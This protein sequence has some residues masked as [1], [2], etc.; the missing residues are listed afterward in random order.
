V[1][2]LGEVSGFIAG[3]VLVRGEDDWPLPGTAWA[4]LYLDAGRT[5]SA[6]SLNDGALAIRPS[7]SS[8]SDMALLAST[9]SASAS[10]RTALSAAGHG[11]EGFG[12]PQAVAP[13]SNLRAAEATA[14]TYT[15]APLAQNLELSGPIVLRV[16]ASATATDFDWAVNLTDVW[17]DG[18]SEWI[19]DG[20]LRASLRRVDQAQSRRN[21]A[22]EIIRPWYPFNTRES[23]PSGEVVEY[24]IELTPISNVFQAGHRIRL[25]L[26]P[27]VSGLVDSA[28]TGGVGTLTVMHGSARPS[29]LL[30]PVVPGRCQTGMPLVDDLAPPDRCANNLAQ[31]L[32]R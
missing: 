11:H 22:G 1:T 8:G 27:A 14:L 26:F 18:R 23:V 29:S 21:A 9:P 19:S 6:A 30:L 31:A 28:L 12:A 32:D 10:F 3:R 20:F 17:P 13:L 7:A 25:D 2:T 15:S 5:G 24:L 4:R 16:F